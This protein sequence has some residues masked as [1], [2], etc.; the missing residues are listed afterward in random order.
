MEK[1][2]EKQQKRSRKLILLDDFERIKKVDKSSTRL[3]IIKRN[4]LLNGGSYQ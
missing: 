4:F 3:T 1:I 2:Q